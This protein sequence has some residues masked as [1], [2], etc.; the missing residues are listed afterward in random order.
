MFPGLKYQVIQTDMKGLGQLNQGAQGRLCY[1]RFALFNLVHMHAD[2][3]SQT[4]LGISLLLPDGNQSFR[5]VHCDNP[6]KTN[7]PN[8]VPPSVF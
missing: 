1:A 7:N 4:L 8:N 5:E 3:I 2:G 6:P